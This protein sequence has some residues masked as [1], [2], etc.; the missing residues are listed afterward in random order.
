MEG[1]LVGMFL[2]FSAIGSVFGGIILWLLAK[3]V[4]K[5]SNATFGNSFLVC[6]ISSVVYI[7]ILFAIGFAALFNLGFAGMVILNFIIL[8]AIYIT[9]GKF[10]WK[11]EYIQSVKANIIWIAFYAISLGAFLSK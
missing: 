7:I 8:S 2:F 11:C 6:L 5:I 9:V 3:F 1:A 4:G 10:I